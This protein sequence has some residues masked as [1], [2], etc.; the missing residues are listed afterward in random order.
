MYTTIIFTAKLMYN[1]NQT[2]IDFKDCD[3]FESLLD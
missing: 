3:A 1:L 2:L